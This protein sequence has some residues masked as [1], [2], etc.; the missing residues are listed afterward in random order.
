MTESVARWLVISPPPPSSFY[1][2]KGGLIGILYADFVSL[3]KARYAPIASAEGRAVLD[4]LEDGHRR[5]HP[6]RTP[7]PP[8]SPGRVRTAGVI[9][10][11]VVWAGPAPDPGFYVYI[12]LRFCSGLTLRFLVG[13]TGNRRCWCSG[14]PRRPAKRF[15]MVE[16]E[17]HHLLEWF[18]RSSG[19]PRL[20]KTVITGRSR[21]HVLKTRV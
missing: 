16:R 21:N 15:Q 14:R 13:P 5:A 8:G 9:G 6:S 2:P 17:A 18:S 4:A 11:S 19:P 12:F 3:P 1:H 7:L 20:Q 10:R